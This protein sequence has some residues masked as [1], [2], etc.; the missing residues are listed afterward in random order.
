M[1]AFTRLAL[2][3][4]RDCTGLPLRLL[5][6]FAQWADAPVRMKGR[7][8][9]LL[10]A[11]RSECSRR[12]RLSAL[13]RTEAM[14]NP[15]SSAYPIVPESPLVI[16][17]PLAY[18]IHRRP[19]L[20]VL[21]GARPPAPLHPPGAFDESM[22]PPHLVEGPSWAGDAAYPY[23][24]D[25]GNIVTPSRPWMPASAFEGLS[26][27]EDAARFYHCGA[28]HHEDGT[29]GRMTAMFTGTDGLLVGRR[30][31][32]PDVGDS[33]EWRHRV[34]LPD[35][36]FTARTGTT[37]EARFGFYL[38]KV[39]VRRSR[40]FGPHQDPFQGGSVHP[41]HWGFATWFVRTDGE[42]AYLTRLHDVLRTLRDDR[43]VPQGWAVDGRCLVLG[44]R[45]GR[46]FRFLRHHRNDVTDTG[47]PT[48]YAAHLSQIRHANWMMGRSGYLLDYHNKEFEWLTD[49]ARVG[50]YVP[51]PVGWAELLG[52]PWG[53]I[54][55]EMPLSLTYL[56]NYLVRYEIGNHLSWVVLFTE[57][58]VM[59]L[60][61]WHR[62]IYSHYQMWWLPPWLLH[63]ALSLHDHDLAKVLGNLR[64]VA[65]CRRLV[66]R[67][68]GIIEEKYRGDWRNVPSDRR[69]RPRSDHPGGF[70]PGRI[71]PG[72]DLLWFIPWIDREVER[73]EWSWYMNHRPRHP[74]DLPTGQ[75]WQ[76]EHLEECYLN[77][78]DGPPLSFGIP[79]Y[80]AAHTEEPVV[81]EEVLEEGSALNEPAAP[82]VV[83]EDVPA[84]E[85]GVE[86][87]EL[88]LHGAFDW[89]DINRRP[90][91]WAWHQGRWVEMQGPHNR[92]GAAHVTPD[93]P[94][95]PIE[96]AITRV[97][98]LRYLGLR[99]RPRGRGRGR[100]RGSRS[101]RAPRH[102]PPVAGPLP[103]PTVAR[104]RDSRGR[105]TRS[106]TVSAARPPRPSAVMGR[107]SAAARV[108]RQE[109]AAQVAQGRSLA[110]PSSAGNIRLRAEEAAAQERASVAAEHGG[111]RPP[112]RR[113]SEAEYRRVKSELR[114][115]VASAAA[116]E[117]ADI[118]ACESRFGGGHRIPGRGRQALRGL[119]TQ[120][121]EAVLDSILEEVAAAEVGGEGEQALANVG[122]SEQDPPL[123]VDE[124]AQAV[125]PLADDDGAQTPKP[126]EEVVDSHTEEEARV[127]CDPH[128]QQGSVTHPGDAAETAA[129]DA[130]RVAVEPASANEMA[131]QDE[132]MTPAAEDPSVG[133]EGDARAPKR[134]ADSPP[135]QASSRF[136]PRGRPTLLRALAHMG[137]QSPHMRPAASGT[138]PPSAPASEQVR[139]ASAAALGAL[140]P[141]GG[142]SSPVASPLSSAAAARV[143]AE[144]PSDLMRDLPASRFVL[145]PEFE[146]AVIVRGR[147][148]DVVPI[149]GNRPHAPAL[150]GAPN[151]DIASAVLRIHRPLGNGTRPLT[152]VIG[153]FVVI[154][155]N[156]P[157]P[158]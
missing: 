78:I 26:V 51:M 62:Q 44:P 133:G 25:Q 57:R 39:A 156:N 100:G 33:W 93:A 71:G 49:A 34:C 151:G 64:N 95:Y 58:C 111:A 146:Y 55:C 22:D 70:D 47:R 129:A 38:H 73:D 84:D 116:R 66:S 135:P 115:A 77:V 155:E 23:E 119:A 14:A 63:M 52:T 32:P 154:D 15:G 21:H 128:T 68:I 9:S 43:T 99:S 46:N 140:T 90:I 54:Y 148:V 69:A 12:L 45:Y 7:S 124:E 147:T 4:G 141:T 67:M 85:T 153:G 132:E 60:A 2:V 48:V 107:G 126:A 136:A 1:G 74:E 158:R 89:G 98:S 127:A 75:D 110:G 91:G 31:Y 101:A 88:A 53:F 40:F 8:A 28:F 103:R 81:V 65:D 106:G 108:E 123:V 6:A 80:V 19:A 10:G 142:P 112:P 109:H 56:A 24:D 117:P 130:E 113:D 86:E 35:N 138:P 150:G 97:H 18:P 30:A 76:T 59:M 82:P 37:P 96:G 92:E 121:V 114:L 87:Y 120:V 105:F 3:G 152:Q 149:V 143:E 139:G 36:A 5:A 131:V 20:S 102:L 42:S 134:R 145:Q 17:S 137:R 122:G 118:D 157:F 94:P 41:H 13:L 79:A 83:V 50:R 11:S 104:A 61:A 27:V 144:A 125:A 72:G 16:L 29:S